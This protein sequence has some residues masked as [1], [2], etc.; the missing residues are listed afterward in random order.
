MGSLPGYSRS[1]TVDVNYCTSLSNVTNLTQLYVLSISAVR[2]SPSWKIFICMCHLVYHLVLP[3]IQAFRRSRGPQQ[4]GQQLGLLDDH[5]VCSIPIHLFIVT[6]A[7]H[8][9][10]WPF[11][12]LA[13][14]NLPSDLG[15]DLRIPIVDSLL[16]RFD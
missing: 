15:T 9:P 3:D 12:S 16:A 1:S 6:P 5:A 8:S 4:R 10:K 13:Q 14:A 11:F 7:Y 2:S